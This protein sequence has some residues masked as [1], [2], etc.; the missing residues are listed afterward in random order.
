MLIKALCQNEATEYC[1]RVPGLLFS[2]LAWL[3]NRSQNCFSQS[4]PWAPSTCLS[5]SLP[6]PGSVL[7]TGLS[8]RLT[9]LDSRLASVAISRHDTMTVSF[10]PPIFLVLLAWTPSPFSASHCWGERRVVAGL[11]C[12][13]PLL[14][15]CGCLLLGHGF[16]PHLYSLVSTSRPH[17][18]S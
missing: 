10:F 5:N 1:A 16:K 7:E 12:S 14:C 15:L 8:A 9:R 17:L 18:Y 2:L 13:F 4:K 3:P 6:P 11:S